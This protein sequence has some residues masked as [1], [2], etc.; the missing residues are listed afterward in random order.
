MAKWREQKDHP[1]GRSKR[2]SP[3]QVV[4]ETSLVSRLKKEHMAYS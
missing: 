4:R 1:E 3:W 2:P